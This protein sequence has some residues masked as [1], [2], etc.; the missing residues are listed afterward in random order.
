M[1]ASYDQLQLTEIMY[2]PDNDG[3]LEYLELY[4]SGNSALALADVSIMPSLKIEY[5]D[6]EP[7]LQ[8]KSF[9]LFVRNLTAFRNW[10]GPVPASKVMGYFTDG[11]L[12]N[13]A[14]LV[15]MTAPDGYTLY[16]ISFP[17]LFILFSLVLSP[18]LFLSAA[19]GSCFCFQDPAGLRGVQGWLVQ[20]HGR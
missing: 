3:D 1:D 11:K 15:E 4:N 10:Y 7:L 2:H 14:E 20:G 9:G 17:F 6:A 5:L 18:C 16:S 12:S 19:H 8:A 13:K